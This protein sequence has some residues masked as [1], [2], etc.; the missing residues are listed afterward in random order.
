V[1]TLPFRPF[2]SHD[3]GIHRPPRRHDGASSL[4]PSLS[5]G[6][7]SAL[8]RSLPRGHHRQAPAQPHMDLTSL[9]CGLGLGQQPSP[10]RLSARRP[11]PM[12]LVGLED[13]LPSTPLGRKPCR[14]PRPSCC[15]T[16][17]NGTLNH[18]T[19]QE[20]MVRLLAISLQQVDLW[21]SL[22]QVPNNLV[23]SR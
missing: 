5:D 14:V 10:R 16:D 3:G 18:Y 7:R 21:M 23:Q 6:K 13:S 20:L 1:L 9:P 2:M 12:N 19:Y 22:H 11:E 15:C 17:L 4:V 8:Q